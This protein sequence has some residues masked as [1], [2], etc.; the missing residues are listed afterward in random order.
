MVI[1]HRIRPFAIADSQPVFAVYADVFLMLDKLALEL[2][3]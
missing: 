2:L 3:F 1:T